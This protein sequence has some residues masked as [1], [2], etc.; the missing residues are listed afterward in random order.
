MI[1]RLDVC[2][3]SRARAADAVGL[4]EFSWLNVCAAGRARRACAVTVEDVA[5]GAKL[6]AGK[7]YLVPVFGVGCSGRVSP[8]QPLVKIR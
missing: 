1:L 3:A 6:A 5:G 7:S 8:A 2:A 4:P